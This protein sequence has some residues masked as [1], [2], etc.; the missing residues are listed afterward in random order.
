MP[1]RGG[2]PS[3]SRKDFDVHLPNLPSL[4]VLERAS[5]GP[6]ALGSLLLCT[7]ST[8]FWGVLDLS[9]PYRWA[10]HW[11]DLVCSLGADCF[12]K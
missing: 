5:P 8:W 3:P 9:A 2:I 11:M 7:H 6:K 1:A 12:W 4:L 10:P